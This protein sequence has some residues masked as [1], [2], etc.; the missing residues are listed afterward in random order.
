MS[1][2]FGTFL[3]EQLFLDFK[4]PDADLT[5][6]T[7]L[8]TGSNVGLGFE[9]AVQLLERGVSRLIMGVRNME[10]GAAAKERMLQRV[11]GAKSD[12]VEVWQLDLASYDNTRAFADKCANE[13]DRL[14]IA[15]LNAAVANLKYRKTADGHE[16]R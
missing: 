15:I 14:D 1:L 16:E 13:L 10:K 3:Y 2:G 4:A 5:G 6:K 9:T 11:P 7:A 12:Q 8:V